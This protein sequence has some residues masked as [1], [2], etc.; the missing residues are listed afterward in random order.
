M[1][2]SFEYY[3]ALHSIY[4]MLCSGGFDAGVPHGHG[5]LVREDGSVVEGEFVHGKF[6]GVA[7]V[8]IMEVP[9]VERNRLQS[10]RSGSITT[11]DSN[12][13]ETSSVTSLVQPA[14]HLDTPC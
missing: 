13:A 3:T 12:S 9:D 14:S 10:S 6:K 5:S 1:V 8:E 7:F 11:G 2:L 4:G